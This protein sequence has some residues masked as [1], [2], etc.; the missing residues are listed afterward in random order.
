MLDGKSGL[1]ETRA[2]P[3]T[4]HAGRDPRAEVTVTLASGGDREG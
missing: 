1:V 2:L 3:H 4:G